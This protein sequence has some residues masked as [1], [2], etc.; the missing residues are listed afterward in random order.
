MD[1]QKEEINKRLDKLD[2]NQ[3]RN[4]LVN[5]LSDVEAGNEIKEIRVKRA[6]EMYD[7]YCKLGG[8][9]YIHDKWEKL[10]K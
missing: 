8:N 9:S 6:Y 4:Y 2:I 7:H 3:C 10:I 1:K 5:F